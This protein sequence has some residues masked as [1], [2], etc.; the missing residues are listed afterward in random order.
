[1]VSYNKLWITLINNGMTKTELRKR[2][3]ISTSTLARLGKNEYVG[4]D[5]ISKI[6]NELHCKIEDVVEVILEEKES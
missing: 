3:G 4:L 5:L 1:M 2:L 6:C